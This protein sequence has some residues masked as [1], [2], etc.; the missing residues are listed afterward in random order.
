MRHR[1]N[2]LFLQFRHNLFIRNTNYAIVLI[3]KDNGF[4]LTAN[5]TLDEIKKC[6]SSITNPGFDKRVVNSAEIDPILEKII[7]NING[8]SEFSVPTD[9]TI[10]SKLLLVFR[11]LVIIS[12]NKT[13]SELINT[14]FDQESKIREL[15]QTLLAEISMFIRCNADRSPILGEKIIDVITDAKGNFVRYVIGDND[16]GNKKLSFSYIWERLKII[17]L[18]DFCYRYF[19][20]EINS[21]YFPITSPHHKCFVD[22]FTKQYE[23]LLNWI[24]H[25]DVNYYQLL[26]QKNDDRPIIGVSSKDIKKTRKTTYADLVSKIPCPSIEHINDETD[27]QVVIDGGQAVSYS[28]LSEFTGKGLLISPPLGGKSWIG[29]KLANCDRNTYY[30]HL[31]QVKEI[32]LVNPIEYILLIA[33]F[34]THPEINLSNFLQ[35]DPRL[36]DNA[37][38]IIDGIDELEIFEIRKVLN[39]LRFFQNC[40]II[41]TCAFPKVFENLDAKK[42]MILPEKRTVP[43]SLFKFYDD[44]GMYYDFLS[45]LSFCSSV[46]G[47]QF[48]I[49]NVN[50][51]LHLIVNGLFYYILESMN[52][53]L[54]RLDVDFIISKLETILDLSDFDDSFYSMDIIRAQKHLDKI[55]KSLECIE[56]PILD[57]EVQK[58]FQ[59]PIAPILSQIIRIEKNRISFQYK[60]FLWIFIVEYLRSKRPDYLHQASKFFVDY[61]FS[62]ISAYIASYMH[63]LPK[64]RQLFQ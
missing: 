52:S 15:T 45:K 58:L 49:Q 47:Y 54:K 36:F 24:N 8:F 9:L 48:V 42:I 2:N 27:L 60:E 34:Q 26:N 56:I 57:S 29:K 38:F 50:K 43:F 64:D 7:T 53:E 44:Q 6:L 35:Y 63:T 61:S 14:S 11:E 19:K 33:F 55:N 59:N 17:D 30:I 37:L 23:S 62:P 46:G 18:P 28:E 31:K 12:I 13:S 10:K 20:I 21:L 5:I 4:N 16:T 25:L 3:K 41:T 40:I 1:I 39:D 51:Q 22:Q 32:G